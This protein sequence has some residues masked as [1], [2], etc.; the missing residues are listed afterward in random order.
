M[1]KKMGLPPS[2]ELLKEF[3]D[4]NPQDGLF[5]WLKRAN[6]N[7]SAEPGTIAGG[8]SGDASYIRIRLKGR[9]YKAHRLA[10]LYVHGEW[11]PEIDHINGDT[12]DNTIANLRPATPS[13]QAANR[14][15]R[16]DNTSGYKGVYWHKP[17]S[18]W[19]AYIYQR[20]SRVN[21]GFFDDPAIA[22]AAY[23]SAAKSLFG[24]FA[25]DGVSNRMEAI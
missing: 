6:Q 7:G 17:K 19:L 15:L 9:F 10:W 22:H 1:S 5:R 2:I 25:Y 21:L 13:Q 16:S 18:K 4:Y 20:G 11:P 24:A 23:V 12:G 3:L 8:P 14:K